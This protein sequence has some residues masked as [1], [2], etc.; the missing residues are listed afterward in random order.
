MSASVHDVAKYILEKHGPMSAMKLQKLLYYSQAWSLVWDD[1]PL[2]N[3][4]IE[5]WS[6]GPIVREAYEVHKGR[7]KVDQW[8]SGDPARLDNDAKETIN[9][10]L[11]F[12]AKRNAQWLSDLTHAEAPWK[13]ARVGLDPEERGNREIALESMMEYYSALPNPGG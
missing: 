5:A 3:E 4:R 1:R 13:K 10:V 12:Y 11:R 6:G 2:F 9:A 8:P 7:F